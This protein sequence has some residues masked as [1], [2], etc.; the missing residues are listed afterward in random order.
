M[1]SIEKFWWKQ[2]KHRLFARN[3][4]EKYPFSS[5]DIYILLNVPWGTLISPI[6]TTEQ[7]LEQ[8]NEGTNAFH[9]CLNYIKE[10]IL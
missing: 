7:R 5:Q 2:R 4:Q 3:E 10:N 6:K 1:F 9:H 8:Q